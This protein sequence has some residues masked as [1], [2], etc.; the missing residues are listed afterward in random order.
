MPL[1]IPKFQKKIKSFILQ[2]S[3]PAL[4]ESPSL[5]RKMRRK[6]VDRKS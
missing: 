2:V 4:L 3:L 5:P 6:N 1:I